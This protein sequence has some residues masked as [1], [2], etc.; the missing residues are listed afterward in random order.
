MTQIPPAPHGDEQPTEFDV[1]GQA[2]LT[3]WR[4]VWLDLPLAWAREA[5]RF[6]YRWGRPTDTGMAG[7]GSHASTDLN[8]A[9]D[10]IPLGLGD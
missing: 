7:P 1:A 2:W 3:F 8:Q 9:A 4:T 6:L 10:T 5:D